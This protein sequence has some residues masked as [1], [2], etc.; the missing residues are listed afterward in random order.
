[1][2]DRDVRAALYSQVLVEHRG[3]RETLIVEEVGICG[4]SRVD[5]A[6]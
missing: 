6:C 4:V 5:V 1:M 3:D 2:R